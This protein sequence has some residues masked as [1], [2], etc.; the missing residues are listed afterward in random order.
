MKKF[1]S[2]LLTVVLFLSLNVHCVTEQSSFTDVL[3]GN[4]FYAAVNK[5]CELG[6]MNGTGED[7]FSPYDAV[8]RAMAVQVLY[9]TSA[10][11]Y[12]YSPIFA[13]VKEDAWYAEA[14]CWAKDKGIATGVSESAFDPSSLM[15][16]EQ[17]ACFI[18]RYYTAY[19]YGALNDSLDEYADMNNVSD[20]AKDSVKNMYEYGIMTPRV[21]NFFYPEATVSRAEFATFILNMIGEKDIGVDTSVHVQLVYSLVGQA[22][23]STGQSVDAK[24]TVYPADSTDSYIT[25]ISE[26]P[27]IAAVD[28]N[29]MITALSSGKTRITLISRDGSYKAYCEITVSEKPSL[30]TAGENVY[31]STLDTS[32]MSVIGRKV[33]PSKPMVAL[34]YDDGPHR[35]YTPQ[36]LDVFESY[37]SAATFFELGNRAENCADILQR[38]VEIGCEVANHSYSHPNLATLSAGAVNNQISTTANIIYNGCGVYPTLVR[39]PYGSYNTTVRNN[40]NAPIITWSVDTLDWKYRDASYVT[41]VI[42]SQVT[43]GSVVLM[44]SLYASTARATEIIVPWLISQGYQLVTVSELAEAR[45]ITLQNGGAYNSFYK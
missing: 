4:W 12:E 26:D 8:S 43:D 35:T 31:Q 6:I 14:V 17:L 23:M 36:I 28:E 34:T 20:W 27:E 16:R 24:G 3:M 19:G 5:I 37:D 39:P 33:D 32:G 11:S 25:Y 21:H 44:H 15:T 2:L 41:S 13:D 42:K 40:V 29:G 18:N 22:V 7:T 30:G 1:V 45:G 10:E 38:E 9:K